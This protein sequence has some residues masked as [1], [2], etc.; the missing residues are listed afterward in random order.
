[1]LKQDLTSYNSYISNEKLPIDETNIIKYITRDDL[2]GTTLQM[3]DSFNGIF[4][5]VNIFSI[6]I[7]IVIM[8]ILIKM[9]IEK[10]ALYISFMKVFGYKTKEINKLYLNA[11]TF[12]VIISLFICIPIEIICFKYALVYISSMIEGYLP[13]YLP[14]SVYIT[15]IFTGIVAYLLINTLFIIKIRK[16]PMNEALKNRE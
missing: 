14:T 2:I 3:L 16:I 8:Y 7:Y 4:D 1:M 6:L 10:N 5:I 13:F 9:V 15:I 12:T 11:T